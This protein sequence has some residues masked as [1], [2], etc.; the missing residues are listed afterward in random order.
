MDRPCDYYFIQEGLQMV[1]KWA[2]FDALTKTMIKI[3]SAW[4]EVQR[5][6]WYFVMSKRLDHEV[7][8]N[9]IIR[10]TF[11]RSWSLWLW[12]RIMINRWYVCLFERLNMWWEKKAS[13]RTVSLEFWC[14]CILVCTRF[15][16]PV[17]HLG[18]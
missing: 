7:F 17:M 12:L 9:D 13:C 8:I 11:W 1:F 15:E 2:D 14:F 10:Y 4:P 6:P 18:V 5:L 16:A 3:P